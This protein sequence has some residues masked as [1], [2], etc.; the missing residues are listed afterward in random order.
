MITDGL[1][2]CNALI[3][4]L[5]SD[6]SLSYIENVEI[7]LWEKDDFPDFN[8]Y[9]LVISPDAF[10]HKLKAQQIMQETCFIQV[11]CI[12]KKFDPVKALLGTLPDK[13]II[14]MTIEVWKSL[15]R[16]FKDHPD[17]DIR[18]N[19]LLEKVQINSRQS[20]ENLDFYY[21]VSIS[22]NVKLKEKLFKDI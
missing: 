17:L 7:Q 21:W 13:G 19:E 20:G 4:H 22:T 1:N 16:F 18:Y 10:S 3:Q 5:Q 11:V 9:G 15:F 14:T 12:V 8:R 2:L 6:A